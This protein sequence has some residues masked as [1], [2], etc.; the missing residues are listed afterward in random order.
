MN[1]ERDS[2]WTWRA[3]PGHE[4]DP[5]LPYAWQY[6]DYMIDSSNQDKPYDLFIKEQIAGDEF[7]EIMGAGDHPKTPA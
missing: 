5:D 6:R 7:E 3:A 1:A 2:G 4:G